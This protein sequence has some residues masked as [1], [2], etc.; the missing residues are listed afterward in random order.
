MLFKTKKLLFILP[1]KCGTSSFVRFIKE[2]TSLI[3]PFNEV[4]RHFLLS[5]KVK[6]LKSEGENFQDY[7]VYQICRNPLNR[8]VSSFLYQEQL[9]LNRRKTTPHNR[10]PKKNIRPRRALHNLDFKSTL[11]LLSPLIPHCPA[12]ELNH[13]FHFTKTSFYKDKLANHPHPYFK[14][15]TM[16]YWQFYMPQYMWNNINTNITYL[17]LEDLSKDCSILSDIFKEDLPKQ[18]P[19]ANKTQ[20]FNKQP[21]IEFFDTETKKLLSEVYYQDFI[22]L[23]YDLV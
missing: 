3:T 4:G 23:G 14:N 22:T 5:D 8:I 11:K 18:F 2:N 6:N 7:Q 1:P 19:L 17:K 21:A 12:L 9:A 15:S 20:L 13:Q 10:N 16:L